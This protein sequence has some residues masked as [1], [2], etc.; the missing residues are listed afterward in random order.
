MNQVEQCRVVKKYELLTDDTITLD[1]GTVLY[2]IRAL[3]DFSDV[4]A[5]ELGGYIEK[6][7]NLDMS[8]D[9]WVSDNARVYGNARVG[10][11]AVVNGRA[12]V[13]GNA[14]VN[15]RARVCGNAQVDEEDAWVADDA[16]GNR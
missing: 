11:N 5:G 16:L 3:V 6:E 15:D 1:D 9:A 7:A 4:K 14:M 13:G 2:R 12:R 8:G 10:G